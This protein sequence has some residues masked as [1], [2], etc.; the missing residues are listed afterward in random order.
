MHICSKF[1]LF[2]I[3]GES[4]SLIGVR[5]VEITSDAALRGDV[6]VLFSDLNA[7]G[8]ESFTCFIFTPVLTE[9]PEAPQDSRVTSASPH[10]RAYNKFCFFFSTQ[11]DFLRWINVK[12]QLRE[13]F[14]LREVKKQTKTGAWPRLSTSGMAL[15]LHYPAEQ[16]WR[17]VGG[18]K[19]G[20]SALWVF[21]M[22]MSVWG[23][24][25]WWG[26]DAPRPSHDGAHLSLHDM[27]S[28]RWIHFHLKKR[29]VVREIQMKVFAHDAQKPS[30][31]T[32]SPSWFGGETIRVMICVFFFSLL[33]D[34]GG[35]AWALTGRVV[36]AQMRR[37][38][39]WFDHHK[40][41]WLI[42]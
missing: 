13:V 30:D 33:L 34:E 21:E 39:V 35:S 42:K 17:T 16:V 27:S 8:R 24:H 5:C 11:T 25:L 9:L 18:T 36:S 29:R 3:F 23:S 12:H 32:W 26:S 6:K 10:R 20:K 37:C 22:Q 38:E 1:G 40:F 31:V 41:L 28:W 7:R 2:G 4:G 15:M 19:T 14:T